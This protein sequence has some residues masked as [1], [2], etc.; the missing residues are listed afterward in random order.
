MVENF[1]LALETFDISVNALLFLQVYKNYELACY[2]ADA[3][4]VAQWNIH[5]W[6]IVGLIDLN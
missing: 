4:D 6:K 5:Q 3:L 2:A 1:V